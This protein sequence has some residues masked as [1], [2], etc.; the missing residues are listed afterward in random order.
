VIYLALKSHVPDAISGNSAP[1]LNDGGERLAVR[2]RDDRGR[3]WLTKPESIVDGIHPFLVELPAEVTNALPEVIL[4][5]P[6]KANF[7]VDT[8]SLS[9]SK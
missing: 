7:W 5:T 1:A 2:L 6:T 8:K 3:Y 9:M 4:V